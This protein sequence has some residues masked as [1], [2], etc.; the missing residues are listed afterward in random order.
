MTLSFDLS[1]PFA[2]VGFAGAVAGGQFWAQGPLQR[3]LFFRSWPNAYRVRPLPSTTIV[4]RPVFASLSA[5]AFALAALGVGEELLAAATA[6]TGIAAAMRTARE[7]RVVRVMP[8]YTRACA[9]R[10]GGLARLRPA[11]GGRPAR[12]GG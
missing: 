2:T 9:A 6:P 11:G 8:G 5:G 7:M 3:L 4:P 10:F 1:M 12:A